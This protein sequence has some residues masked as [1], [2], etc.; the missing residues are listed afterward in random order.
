MSRDVDFDLTFTCPNQEGLEQVMTYLARKKA[1]CDAWERRGKSS[2]E[3]LRR[4]GED[5]YGAVVSWG[6]N[7]DDIVVDEDGEASVHAT[8]WAN[9]NSWNVPISGE[10]GE[11]ADLLEKFPTLTIAGTYKDEYGKSG[12]IH[13]F[14]E[15]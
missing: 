13:G 6:F 5:S 8:S 1:R 12:D 9:Q 4:V 11:L 7:F 15:C 14:S 3:L 2:K 10:T